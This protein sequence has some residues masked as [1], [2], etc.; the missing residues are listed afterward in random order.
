MNHMKRWPA[1]LLLALAAGAQEAGTE[2]K[3]DLQAG[4]PTEQLRLGYG[5]ARRLL[6]ETTAPRFLL[7]VPK[8]RAADPLFLR[9]SLGE[10]KG[11]PFYAA[12]D[13]SPEGSFH[14]VLHI[15]RNRDL[16]LTNDGEPVRGRTS[17]L[18]SSGDKL[19]E[20]TGVTL[21]VPYTVDGKE[22]R[23]PYTCLFYYV[24]RPEGRPKTVQVERDGWRQGL[25]VLGETGFVVALVDDD[26]DGQYTNGDSWVLRPVDEDRGLLLAADSTRSMLFP[27]WSKDQKW[28]VDV[29]S[30]DP[31]GRSLVAEV[32]P[33]KESEHDYFTRIAAARQSPE[34]R[35]LKLDPLRPKAKDGQAIDWI[36]GK[37]AAYA[38][39]IARR[40]N[41]RKPVLL[42][43]SAPGCEWC[44]RME[45]FTY[46]D[47]EVVQLAGR[48]VCAKIAFAPGTADAMKHSV[49]ATPT[50]IVLDVEGTEIARQNGF[51]RP[52]ELAAWLKSALR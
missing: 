39:D 27:S 25:L 32:R 1:A 29:K 49:S 10:T 28:A 31:A 14:D 20:F 2:V 44:A 46:R 42:E 35:R 52:T 12:L 48:F 33:A 36:T 24:A 45:Q 51:A 50:L 9:V 38:L 22:E 41:V 34:E 26:S 8:L 13:R 11:V 43:F 40:A 19:V 17:T 16:D 5:S 6:V 37:D 4:V 3:V 18:W 21:D 23:E 7:Q 47:R 30:V 15:D